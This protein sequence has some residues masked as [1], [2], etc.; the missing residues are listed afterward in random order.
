MTPEREYTDYLH[1]I[2][3]AI[4][5]AEQFTVGMD[6]E[7]FEDDDKT[8]FAV[9]RALE[10]IGEATKAVPQHVRDHYPAVPWQQMAGMRDILIHKY[11]GVDL[12][13]VW[14]TVQQDLPALKPLIVQIVEETIHGGDHDGG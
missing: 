8:A 9:I 6:F 1:D 7:Q 10:V 2:L 3:D 13:V 12:R 11:F 5:K 4:E 14:E